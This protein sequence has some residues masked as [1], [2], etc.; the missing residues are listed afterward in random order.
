M[1][2][3]DYYGGGRIALGQ[4]RIEV[5]DE[6]RMPIDNAF[7]HIYEYQN[8]ERV[9]INS[10]TSKQDGKSNIFSLHAPNITF[11]FTSS[12]IRP[13]SLYDIEIKKENY[14]IEEIKNVPI[15]PNNFSTL[16]IMLKKIKGTQKKNSTTI[17][18]HPLYGGNKYA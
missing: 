10:E 11:S 5:Y 1:H 17:P 14:D 7:I 9:R 3:I 2:D 13:Y 4:I 8:K 18:E 15:F 12:F 16:P 6:N